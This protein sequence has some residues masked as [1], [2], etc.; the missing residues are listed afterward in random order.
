MS[1]PSEE[2]NARKLRQELVNITNLFP[3]EHIN[4]FDPVV[5]Y[6]YVERNVPQNLLHSCYLSIASMIQNLPNCVEPALNHI[7]D[8]LFYYRSYASK[9][10]FDAIEEATL[11]S[12]QD[13]DYPSVALPNLLGIL[14]KDYNFLDYVHL[15]SMPLPSLRDLKS[16]DLVD[17]LQSKLQRVQEELTISRK[18]S[19]KISIDN[20]HMQKIKEEEIKHLKELLNESNKKVD[21]KIKE[22]DRLKAKIGEQIQVKEKSIQEL[23][24]KLSMATNDL[25]KLK[26]AKPNAAEDLDDD[27][28]I[29]RL[30]SVL[31][32][33]EKA[34]EQLKQVKPVV[35]T[36]VDTKEIDNLK[37][38]LQQSNLENEK[39]KNSL[40]EYQNQIEVFKNALPNAAEDMEDDA[41]ITRLKE[42]IDRQEKEL[43]VLRVAKPNAAEDLEDDKEIQRL[44]KLLQ[45]KDEEILNAKA[46]VAKLQLNSKSSQNS[47]VPQNSEP[48]QN[49][50]TSQNNTSQNSEA[51]QNSE[52]P[53]PPPPVAPPPP[54][55]APPPPPVAPPPPGIGLPPPPP[56]AFGIPPPPPGVG[57]PPPP[58]GSLLAKKKKNTA[59]PMKMKGFFWQK[60]NENQIKGSKW[61]EM[62]EV[63]IDTQS[64][65]D[66]FPVKSKE[67]F[68]SFDLS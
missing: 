15:Q 8:F 29:Q 26:E 9:G 3:K 1:I 65:M 67:S 60:L 55:M 22:M 28:E 63:D 32:E 58:P 43:S 37:I 31:E 27:K 13:T 33:K 7:L 68:S 36:V 23:E 24:I 54:P 4:P 19:D 40:V 51:S 17:D 2:E 56:P 57:V 6:D 38:L 59:P 5:L 12:I 49:S 42:V 44:K 47:E 21:D 52:S 20:A 16:L 11:L 30:Q 10:N 50:E 39:M 41:E 34:I 66:Q 25:K 35:T 61:S 46:E 14:Y 18:C 48:K 64:L 45:Q 62:E 53:S